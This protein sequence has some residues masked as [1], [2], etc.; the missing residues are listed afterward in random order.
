MNPELDSCGWAED[1]SQQ[2]WAL[3]EV[4]GSHSA[5][6][7]EQNFS[8]IS[9]QQNLCLTIAGDL[10]VYGSMLSTGCANV[11]LLNRSPKTENI[12][13]FM[14]DLVNDIGFVV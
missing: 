6:T 3:A 1:V 13:V 5:T 2:Q 9:L 11:V 12:T 7:N 4:V 10:E 14:K 8:V